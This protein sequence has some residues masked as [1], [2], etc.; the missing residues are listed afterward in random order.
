MPLSARD[1]LDAFRAKYTKLKSVA[2]S[3]RDASG[4]R[5][6]LK[7]RKGG[8]YHVALS[9]RSIICDGKT[10]WNVV[11]RT[12]TVM[13]NTYK[14]TS[15]DVSLERVFFL[16]L[17]IYRPTLVSTSKQT[18]TIRL[19]APRADAVIANIEQIDL[20]LD[21]KNMITTVSVNEY[22]TTTTWHLSKLVLNKSMP[23]TTFTYSVP[24]GW[25]TVD[26][27]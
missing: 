12:K 15:D 17:N 6:T 14:T 24:V 16:M 26:L 18:S 9:D 20:T 10:V 19:T 21:R 5:G 3:F 2:C 23:P 8:L 4:M 25:Q 11:P 1:A 13:M 7:A 22:G 27:R